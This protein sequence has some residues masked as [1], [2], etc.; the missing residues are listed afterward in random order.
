MIVELVLGCWEISSRIRKFESGM[1][2]GRF[3]VGCDSYA[4]DVLLV[5][6]SVAAVE[7]VVAEV[8]AILEEV[9]LSLGALKTH[10]TSHPKMMDK[11]IVVHRLVVLCERGPEILW[12]RRCVSEMLD[13]RL[14]T[15]LLT[16]ISVW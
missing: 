1:E 10:W 8:V 2:F 11:S 7:V 6:A 3:C 5:A 15:D 12:C 4:D 14:H 13:T 9:G 16:P